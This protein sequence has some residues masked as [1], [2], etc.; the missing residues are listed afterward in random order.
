MIRSIKPS[1]LLNVFSCAVM[2]CLLTS[3]A[4]WAIDINQVPA[5]KRSASGLHLTAAEAAAMKQANPNKVLFI[6]IRTRAEAMYLGMPTI[7]E[8]L[9][10]CAGFFGSMGVES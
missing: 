5:E 2:L 8:L 1:R 4:V 3:T 6:D 9:S 7:A 10:S